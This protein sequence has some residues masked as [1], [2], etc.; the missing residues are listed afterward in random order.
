MPEKSLEWILKMDSNSRCDWCLS[1]PIYI[2]YHDNEWGHYQ[3]DDKILFEFLLLEG[4]QAGLSWITILRKRENYRIA[5][6]NFD[7]NKI[8][9]YNKDKIE[10][11][12][13]NSGIIRNRRKIASSIQNAR[14]FIEVKKEFGSFSNYLDSFMTDIPVMGD[15]NNTSEV[16]CSSELSD[17]VSLDLKKRGFSFVGTKIIYSFLQA[18]GRIND[19]IRSCPF[20]G[21][22]L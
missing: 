15:Y 7:Y 12:L 2:E 10:T 3:N 22:R 21:K 17:T 9:N 6:D 11:L 13:Q 14:C 5:Y 18:T 19:H 20:G 8:A 1:D 16:P 4:A